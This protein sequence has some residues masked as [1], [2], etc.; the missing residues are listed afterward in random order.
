[1]LEKGLS[2]IKLD[3]NNMQRYLS[4]LLELEHLVYLKR[5]HLYSTEEW[6]ESQFLLDV[7]GKFDISFG[8]VKEDLGKLVAFMICSEP[9]P[10]VSHVNRIAVHPKHPGDNIGRRLMLQLFKEWNNMPQFKTLTG[11]IRLDHKL[12]LPFT[13]K[14]GAQI[15]D[16]S[17]MTHHFKQIGR[18]DVQI[19]DD[20]FKDRY[21]ISYALIYFEK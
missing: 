5:G 13:Q 10:G 19:F 2:I 21:G 1:M 18:T 14:L 6:G 12:S 11:I 20:H 7:P 15:A 16:K 17:Y 4:D 9:I 8:V 3:K